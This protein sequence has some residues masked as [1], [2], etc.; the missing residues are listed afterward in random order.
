MNNACAIEDVITHCC[1]RELPTCQCV[2]PVTKKT[3]ASRFASRPHQEQ[4]VFK[5]AQVPPNQLQLMLFLK[6]TSRSRGFPTISCC[7]T[8]ILQVSMASDT[9]TQFDKPTFPH[10]G[11]LP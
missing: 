6:T 10:R 8:R 1:R 3:M 11:D 2:M 4:A 9:I 7:Y 5:I